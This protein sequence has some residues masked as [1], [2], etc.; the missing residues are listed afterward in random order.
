MADLQLARGHTIRRDRSF[1]TDNR[2]VLFVSEEANI[3]TRLGEDRMDIALDPSQP[4]PFDASHEIDKL[5]I[6]MRWLG[7]E[8]VPQSTLPSQIDGGFEFELGD[9]RFKY[10]LLGLRRL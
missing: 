2:E 4:S 5:A 9:R 1:F 3:R 8:G 7:N 10:D 6:S